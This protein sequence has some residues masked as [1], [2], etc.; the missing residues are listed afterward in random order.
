MLDVKATKLRTGVG[1]RLLT[2]ALLLILAAG[3][4]F[5][6]AQTVTADHVQTWPTVSGVTSTSYPENG[7]DPV[8]TYS[9]TYPSDTVGEGSWSLT[10]S[11]YNTGGRDSDNF[12]ISDSG[13]LSFVTSPN[14]E[15][16]TDASHSDNVYEITVVVTA[17]REGYVGKDGQL[18][19]MVAELDVEVT[20]T[21]VDE[22]SVILTV[23][24]AP[25]NVDVTWTTTSSGNLALRVTWDP[26]ASDGNGLIRRYR[27]G[28]SENEFTNRNAPATEALVQG[29]ITAGETYSVWVMAQNQVGWGPKSE[30]VSYTVPS[31]AGA[32]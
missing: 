19:P 24:S 3:V 12:T 30:A 21:D 26:P 15:Q 17:F 2:G 9:A 13:V 18:L 6:I 27:A 1:V 7:T 8:A 22:P 14:Y 28:R 10:S 25:L 20:V 32:E 11:L 29:V 23:P 16:P 4:V 5:A 31:D